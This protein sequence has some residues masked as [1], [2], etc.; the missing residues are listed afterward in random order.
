VCVQY[1]CVGA[2]LQGVW[3][4]EVYVCACTQVCAHVQVTQVFKKKK[5]ASK[6]VISYDC[7]RN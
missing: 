3:V 2:Y 5:V 4:C 1:V 7:I 6:E